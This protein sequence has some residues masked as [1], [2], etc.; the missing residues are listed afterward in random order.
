[1]I[2]FNCKPVDFADLF[3]GEYRA[4][5]AMIWTEKRRVNAGE[6]RRSAH[7]KKAARGRPPAAR[8]CTYRPFFQDV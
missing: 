8:R 2:V 7:M 6:L 4:H 1:M 3:G 5:G